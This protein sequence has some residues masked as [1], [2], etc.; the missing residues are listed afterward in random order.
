MVCLVCFESLFK[1]Q[2]SDVFF[3]DK[4]HMLGERPAALS[5]GH[6]FHKDCVEEWLNVSATKTCPFCSELSTNIA[7]PLFIDI[8]EYDVECVF[9]T[10]TS[11]QS[12][13]I[14]IAKGSLAMEMNKLAAEFLQAAD[15]NADQG[16]DAQLLAAEQIS[17][18]TM[19]MDKQS[20]EINKANSNIEHFTRRID[21]LSVSL[22]R[23][24]L[25][26]K[27]LRNDSNLRDKDVKLLVTSQPTIQPAKPAKSA[28]A[29]K[30]KGKGQWKAKSKFKAGG[31]VGITIAATK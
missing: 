12:S 4:N 13:G 22:D 28:N 20:R 26:V 10:E 14:Q 1:V 21:R 18:I 24:K 11:G 15:N 6:V 3:V 30:G 29:N 9:L 31:N 27:S 25:L 17:L 16:K 8:E 23:K 19:Q 5:C 2:G 7:Q